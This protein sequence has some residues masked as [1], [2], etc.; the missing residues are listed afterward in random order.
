MLG[1]SPDRDMSILGNVRTEPVKGRGRS[2]ANAFDY[3]RAKQD[4]ALT[5][6]GRVTADMSWERISHFSNA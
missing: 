6:A 4:P 1:K 5:D 3:A 2:I